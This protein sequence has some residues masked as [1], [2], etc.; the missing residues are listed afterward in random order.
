M[1]AF[2]RNTSKYWA[3]GRISPETTIGIWVL[4]GEISKRDMGLLKRNI[5]YGQIMPLYTCRRLLFG[6]LL[7]LPRVRV[8]FGVLL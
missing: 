7:G 8:L 2:Y 4:S 1:L 6:V 3:R 5:G